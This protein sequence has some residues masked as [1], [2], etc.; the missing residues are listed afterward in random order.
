MSSIRPPSLGPI[1]GHTTSN[2]C[3]LWVRAADPD[4]SDI[5]LNKN[6]RTIGVITVL[7]DSDKATPFLLFFLF[8]VII[9]KSTPFISNLFKA[10]LKYVSYSFSF[11]E[12][13]SP[14]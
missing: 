4:D 11:H 1:I 12:E 6:R 2:S 7:N 3:R 9:A 10:E 8:A 13:T 5:K 14:I